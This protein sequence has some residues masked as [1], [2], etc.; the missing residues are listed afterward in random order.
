VRVMQ[1]RGSSLIELLVA[2]PLLAL[3]G[4]VAVMLLLFV[5]RSARMQSRTLQVSRELR[6]AV[7]VLSH[8][9]DRLRVGDV[10]AVSDT[11]LEFDAR[12]GAAVVCDPPTSG[13]LV[14][15][16]VSALSPS[17]LN[18]VR[19]GDA[20]SAWR[21]PGVHSGAGIV[22]P[23]Q[24]AR[25]SVGTWTPIG[26]GPCG[27]AGDALRVPRWRTAV[28]SMW[29]TDIVP[30]TPVLL[31]RRTRYTHYRSD[32]QW[33]IGRRALDVSGWET[34]QPLAGPLHSVAANGMTVQAYDRRG[35]V[36]TNASDVAL[37]HVT[38]RAPHTAAGRIVGPGDSAQVQLAL[39][40]APQTDSLP[41]MP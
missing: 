11:L 13:Q 2:L 26:T 32:G 10:L 36:T 14:V 30:G 33:W 17:P 19:A 12:L 6:H 5:A 41:P 21:T 35:A 22:G 39:R 37:L 27:A 20:L 28:D 24:S 38:L 29:A 15:G 1:R 16:D 25:T 31:Q 4:S 9:I 7:L 34:V 3:L 8:D 40:G 18:V 23:P